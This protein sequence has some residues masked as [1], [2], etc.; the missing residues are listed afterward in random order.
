MTATPSTS[1]LLLTVKLQ[2]TQ[3]VV[4]E[5]PYLYED[6]LRDVEGYDYF[7]GYS[8]SSRIHNNTLHLWQSGCRAGETWNCTLA[9]SDPDTG[10]SM[11]WN[12]PEAMF[13]LHNCLAYPILATAAAHGWL[14]Q[15]PPGLLDSFGILSD[16]VLPFNLTAGVSMTSTSAWPV[17]NGCLQRVCTEFNGDQAGSDCFG[18]DIHRTSYRAGPLDT[19]WNVSLVSLSKQFFAASRSITDYDNLGSGRKYRLV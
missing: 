18:L 1:T 2:P 16:D 3:A 7:S 19:L 17:I 13:T 8:E 6:A 5:E 10:P 4:S 12:S 14:V 15:D 11:V 9:C